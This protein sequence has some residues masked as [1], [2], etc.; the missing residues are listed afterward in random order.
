MTIRNASRVALLAT[1]G[2]GVL[3]ACSDNS[4][5]TPIGASDAG[6]GG[7]GGSAGMVT[8]AGTAPSTAGTAPSTAG[9]AP[10]T[11]GTGGAAAG[12][13]GAGGGG[14]GGGGTGGASGGT[15]AAGTAGTGGTP[16]VMVPQVCNVTFTGKGEGSITYERWLQV[17]G[18]GVAMIPVNEAADMTTTLTELKQGGTGLEQFGAR[19]RGYLTAPLAGK[20][21]FW[22]AGDDNTEVWLSTSDDPAG[23]VRIA[24]VEG[25]DSGWTGETEWNKFSSQKSA[26]ITL[27]ADKKYYLE[28]LHKEGVNLD[29]VQVGWQ[30]PGESGLAPCEVVPGSVLTPLP[31]PVGGEGGAGGAE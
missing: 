29:H 16:P 10:S 21:R 3:I 27:E 4:I 5:P 18:T 26:E 14:A 8:T 30:V 2:T 15:P 23:K 24:W 11:A 22:I 25:A 9:T 31:P 1:L 13:G 20:Y 28:V 12:S 19:L 7:S 17:M 6:S